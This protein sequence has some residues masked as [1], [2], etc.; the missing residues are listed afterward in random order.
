MYPQYMCIL[1]YVT[2]ILCN[3]IWCN[4]QYMCILLYVVMMFHRFIDVYVAFFYC[5]TDLVSIGVWGGRCILSICAFS[6]M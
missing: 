2:L 5:I 3:H 4:L 1:L 6:Y